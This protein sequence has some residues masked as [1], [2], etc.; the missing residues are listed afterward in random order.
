MTSRLKP[1]WLTVANAPDKFTV[2]VLGYGIE[3]GKFGEQDY[4]EGRVLNI[5]RKIKLN[6]TSL[7]FLQ[8]HGIEA[9]EEVLKARL[10]FRKLRFEKKKLGSH[11]CLVVTALVAE[12]K[13]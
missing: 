5:P 11:N 10:L 8:G 3:D 12:K 4:I 9:T 1:S 6:Q 7:L 2:E 13:A